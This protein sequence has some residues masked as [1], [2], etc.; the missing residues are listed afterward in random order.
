[1][2]LV[3]GYG[4]VILHVGAACSCVETFETAML[5]ECLAAVVYENQVAEELGRA[6]N[7]LFL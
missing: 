4:R 1:M 5:N 3:V 7:A 6:N 2:Q